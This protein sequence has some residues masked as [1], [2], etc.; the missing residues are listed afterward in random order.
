MDGGKEGR[1][2]KWEDGGKKE[3]EDGWRGKRRM[4]GLREKER[5]DER[6]DERKEGTGGTGRQGKK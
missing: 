1:K 5:E 4:G 3:W 2:N 6:E